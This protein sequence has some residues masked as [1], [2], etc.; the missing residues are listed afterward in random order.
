MDEVRAKYYQRY[1]TEE[2][3]ARDKAGQML[4]GWFYDVL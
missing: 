3:Q 1:P 2:M 4:N